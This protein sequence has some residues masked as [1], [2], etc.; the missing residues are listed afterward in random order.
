M[1][2]APGGCRVWGREI[3]G[4]CWLWHGWSNGK[5]H[6]RVCVKGRGLYLHRLSLAAFQGV[7]LEL[8]DNC[9]HLCRN[10]NCF[11]PLHIESV[12][13]LENYYRGDGPD[14]QFKTNFQLAEENG[15]QNMLSEDDLTALI[16]GY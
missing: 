11:Q 15:Q 9:D 1:E 6:G 7:P 8:L 4:P 10:R 2:P 13:P 3:L 12:T 5:G 16:R 14:F